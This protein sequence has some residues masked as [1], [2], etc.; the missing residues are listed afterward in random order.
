[1]RRTVQK[2]L[3]VLDGK[4]AVRTTRSGQLPDAAPPT[5]QHGS[6]QHR[7][8]QRRP[9]L[10]GQSLVEMTITFPILIMMIVSTAEIGFLANNYLTLMDVVRE[11]ARRSVTQQVTTFPVGGMVSNDPATRTDGARN[12][13]RLDCEQPTAADPVAPFFNLTGANIDTPRGPAGLNYF[14]P[15]TDV[16]L[17][18]YDR[19][20][21][22]AINNMQPL[23]FDD[24]AD[25]AGLNV[26]RDD[27]VISV[28][29]YV[30]VDLNALSPAGSQIVPLRDRY[31]RHYII[32]TGRYPME[33]RYCTG[34]YRDPFD[35]WHP[36]FVAD[37]NTGLFATIGAANEQNP[38]AYNR[39]VRELYNPT[40]KN[41]PDENNPGTWVVN[42]R[43]TA[44]PRIF[45]SNR[46][47]VTQSQGIRG[48][49]LTG[50]MR[51]DANPSCLGSKFTIGRIED[52]L[53]A[54]V[55]VAVPEFR[56]SM[57]NGAL[58]IVEMQWEH[59]AW[60]LG[61]FTAGFRDEAGNPIANPLL[62]VFAIFPVNNATPTATPQ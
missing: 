50:A 37:A 2:I 19:V 5:A 49:A 55:G 25:D 1:M 6:F 39:D 15:G 48:Y 7:P 62:Y 41:I 24:P 38:E 20:M 60:F 8:H 51:D 40:A 23:V 29:S 32:V 53:N 46:G 36:N 43:Y 52:T 58:V 27:L 35:F 10:R 47:L 54:A 17:G 34:D 26:S 57:P 16:K 14:N 61:P 42:P 21:C 28:V 13:Q 22:E 9:F 45:N 12:Y 3:D 11:G 56:E 30:T 33:N 59:T 4:P 18:F 31:G 44:N